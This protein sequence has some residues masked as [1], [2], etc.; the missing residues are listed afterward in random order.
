MSVP[1]PL[2]L[3]LATPC[4]V[5]GLVA[6]SHSFWSVGR[7]I[8]PMVPGPK[9]SVDTGAESDTRVSVPRRCRPALRARVA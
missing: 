7:G 4:G 3:E 1:H 9:A 2:V 8:G 5:H 6:G